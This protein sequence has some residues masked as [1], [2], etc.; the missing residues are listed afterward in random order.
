[1]LGGELAAKLLASQGSG[2]TISVRPSEVDFADAKLLTELVF[3]GSWCHRRTVAFC[4]VAQ[5]RG[6][7]MVSADFTIPRAI[8]SIPALS[9]NDPVLVPLLT[10]SKDI[11][12]RADV[13]TSDEHG[14]R[15]PIE[16]TR[17][18]RLA[19]C[20]IL[21]WLA[22]R[23]GLWSE[24]LEIAAPLTDTDTRVSAHAFDSVED[25][26][27]ER[28]ASWR[29]RTPT[30]GRNDLVDFANAARLFQR[31]VLVLAA[32]PRT[33][34][35]ARSRKLATITYDAPIRWTR[36]VFESFGLQ[37]LRIAPLTIFGGDADSYH[38]QLDPPEGVVVV[39]TRLL[40]SYTA[41]HPITVARR[42]HGTARADDPDQLLA[43]PVGGG[44]RPVEGKADGPRSDLDD[45]TLAMARP[46]PA[47]AASGRWRR[48]WGFVLGSSEPMPAHVR[49]GG[50]R[51]PRL[52][53]GRDVVT[54]FHVYPDISAYAGLLVAAVVNFA[55]VLG[56]FVVLVAQ[57]GTTLG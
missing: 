46:L 55:Y 18:G 19:A 29:W 5:R 37:P 4:F 47:S 30:H 50:G 9:E 21:L 35:F 52:L 17:R 44:A 45:Y 51:L 56:L 12:P 41:R 38:V 7:W 6:H 1:M 16:G 31:S 34:A 10:A 54:I 57:G 14:D 28:P 23:A 36:Q 33:A 2:D 42:V 40:Y 49:V 43:A 20:M 8:L 25:V 11:M 22:H 48:R 32:F 53:D 26:L 24:A 39:D 27:V 13:I 15:F 3:E